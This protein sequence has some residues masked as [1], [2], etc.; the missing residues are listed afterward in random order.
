[1]KRTAVLVI[2]ALLAKSE[3]ANA[4]ELLKAHRIS[5]DS[6][7]DVGEEDNCK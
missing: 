6:F 3:H 1:M 7:S 2:A 5:A 4:T